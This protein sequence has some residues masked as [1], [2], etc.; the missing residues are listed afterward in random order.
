MKLRFTYMYF[1]TE[2]VSDYGDWS[3]CFGDWVLILLSCSLCAKT[4][5]CGS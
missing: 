2:F 4:E 3:P 5:V 1:S